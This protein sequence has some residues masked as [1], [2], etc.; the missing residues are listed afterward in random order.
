MTKRI[1]FVFLLLVLSVLSPKAQTY[2]YKMKSYGTTGNEHTNVSGGQFLTFQAAICMETN[3]DGESVGHGYLKR[4]AKSP[5]TYM[6]SAYWGNTTKFLFSSDK[7]TLKVL[8]PDGTIYHYVRSTPPV[9]A[10]TCSLLKSKSSKNT[11]TYI[12][13]AGGTP[14]QKPQKC[15][16]CYGSGKCSQ[17]NGT[18]ISSFGH[19]HMCGGCGGSGKCGTCAGSGYSGTVTEYIY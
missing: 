7:S 1:E 11:P 15:G 8:A 12:P 13:G 10:T 18:G 5:N 2:Y 4:N 19:K 3:K 16:I 17:C 9:G 6:G 14:I